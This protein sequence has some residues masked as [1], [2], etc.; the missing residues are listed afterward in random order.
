MAANGAC[1]LGLRKPCREG[2]GK[3]YTHPRGSSETLASRETGI[4][5]GLRRR[6]STG[7]WRTRREGQR[8]S[9]GRRPCMKTPTV[10]GNPVGFPGQWGGMATVPGA[11][12]AESS[13]YHLKKEQE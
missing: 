6:H 9:P 12:R 5:A 3:D 1:S 7:R 4:L 13:R 2:A 8:R 10:V 11:A